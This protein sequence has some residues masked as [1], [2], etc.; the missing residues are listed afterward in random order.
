MLGHQSEL[1]NFS[2]GI[3][4]VAGADPGGS[5]GSQAPPLQKYIKEAKR[6]MYWYK[7]LKCIIS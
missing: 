4:I 7:T 5:L 2:F 1:A 3:C 6:V